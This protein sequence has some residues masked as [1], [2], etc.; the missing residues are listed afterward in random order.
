MRAVTYQAHDTGEHRRD[1][2]DPLHHEDEPKGGGF[3]ATVNKSVEDFAHEVLGE[4]K[5]EGVRA[6]FC[7]ITWR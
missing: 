5:G 4:E 1:G 7:E 3:D 6:S 2:P